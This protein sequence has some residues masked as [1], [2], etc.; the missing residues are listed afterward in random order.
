MKSLY[1]RQ[2]VFL[3]LLFI[4]FLLIIGALIFAGSASS[5]EANAMWDEHHSGGKKKL[6][7]Y[8][9][10]NI[11]ISSDEKV[12]ADIIITD[13]K[14]TIKG[15][16]FGDVIA[17]RSEVKFDH[18]GIVYGN[19]VS[20]HSD[21][22]KEEGA[23]IAGDLISAGSRKIS[24]SEYNEIEDYSV[25]YHVFARPVTDEDTAQTIII[26][27]NE[28]IPGDIIAFNVNVLA[29]G[30]VDGDFIAL[31]SKI[32]I[33]ETAAV[34]GHV[35][36]CEGSIKKSD[37]ALVTG[38]IYDEGSVG[39]N[40]KTVEQD[41]DETKIREAVEEKYLKSQNGI[42]SNVVRFFGDVTI[43]EDEILDGDVVV[44]KG[45]ILVLGEV[46]GDVVSIF[47]N[48]ELDSTAYV[49]GDVVSVGG[50]IYRERGAHVGGDVVQT[51][52]TG[53]KVD[54]GDQHVRVGLSGVRIR[55]KR[56]DEWNIR[57]RRISRWH[58]EDDATDNFLARYNRVEGLFLGVRLPRYYW[59][60]ATRLNVSLYGHAGYGFKSKKGRYQ[61][62]LERWFFDM[63]RF[64]IGGEAHD[65]TDTQD[66]WII[67]TFENSLAAF[68]LRED[69]Q[70]YYR[71]V[72]ASGYVMQNIT[73]N[74]RLVFGYKKDKFYSMEKTTNWSLFG[75]HKK[76][77]ENPIIVED[78]MEMKSIYAEI[79]LDTRN[80][81][82]YPAQ[83]WF[84]KAIGEFVRPDLNDN[85]LDFDRF[86]IDLRRYQPLGYG[87]NLDFR[88][89][90]GSARGELPLQ[91]QYD[92]GG[93]STLRG[94]PFKEFENGDRMILGNVEYR[95]YGALKDFLFFDDLNF[96]LFADAGCVWNA[97]DKT[98]PEKSFK[99]LDWDDLKTDVGVALCNQKGNVR[100]TFA[101]RMDDKDKPI[102]V[103]FR[104]RR[105]F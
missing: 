11:I 93:I 34:D 33:S 22:T 98:G 37:E 20:Y 50:R 9:K 99:Q 19:V 36:N 43:E 45:T 77:S 69:F 97:E 76:F 15:E 95:I 56:G 63:C 94:Y 71:R 79:G 10:D 44:M 30:K 7:R 73:P 14:L 55:P 21:V 68:F 24:H 81:I 53:V 62:G 96:I 91:F 1:Y 70:D 59:N 26:D 49:S 8:E 84:I 54:D 86:I 57:K 85:G 32:N 27:E 48:V 51:S 101:Q 66:K 38:V 52:W 25:P 87:E 13:G 60:E 18:T 40:V 103:T 74:F 105:P 39:I 2:I 90:V 16:I 41:E 28:T 12:K 89:R 80:S 42:E 61:V 67:S 102:V 82:K 17:L 75:G 92:L 46:D 5:A 100:V 64:T 104:I 78:E 31:S 72:G 4:A 47:G 23:K 29:H 83:G 3:I 58:D 65:L 88:F 35:I 6:I